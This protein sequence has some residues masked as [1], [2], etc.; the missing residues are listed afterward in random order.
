MK[1]TQTSVC[2]AH[3]VESRITSGR[4]HRSK[5]L[6]KAIWYVEINWFFMLFPIIISISCSIYRK[7][8]CTWYGLTY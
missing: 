2:T 4:M 3:F 1:I 5:I 7:E 8:I 6:H